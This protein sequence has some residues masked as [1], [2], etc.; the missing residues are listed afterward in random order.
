[1]LVEGGAKLHASVL[2]SGLADLVQI[3]IAP[4]IIGGVDARPVVG[5]KGVELV[6]DAYM[7]KAPKVTRFGDD[8]LLEYRK[9]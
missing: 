6:K 9:A 7:F 1:V 5:G 4:K 8:I 2:E 3:Y